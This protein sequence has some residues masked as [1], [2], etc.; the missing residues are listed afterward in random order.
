MVGEGDGWGGG[1]KFGKS[2]YFI[3]LVILTNSQSVTILLNKKKQQKGNEQ[4]LIF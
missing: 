3:H 1:G 2:V 4:H